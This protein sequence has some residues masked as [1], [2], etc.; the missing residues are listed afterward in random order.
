L[1]G[2]YAIPTVALIAAVVLTAA[3]CRR[4]LAFKKRVS[5]GTILVGAFIPATVFTNLYPC[6]EDGLAAFSDGYW[7]HL[8]VGGSVPLLFIFVIWAITF[9]FCILA[10]LGVVVYYQKRSKRDDT[11]VV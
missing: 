7:A 6:F 5:I 8:K 10:A 11:Q 3:I 2:H 9:F 4:R 1:L